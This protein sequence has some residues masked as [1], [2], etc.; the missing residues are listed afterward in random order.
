LNVGNNTRDKVSNE[1]VLQ[2]I[3][4]EDVVLKITLP[5]D[6]RMEQIVVTTT[7]KI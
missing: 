2:R 1:L 3:N 6:A 4:K 5:Q 7:K